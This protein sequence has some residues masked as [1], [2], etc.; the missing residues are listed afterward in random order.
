MQR[1]WQ[2]AAAAFSRLAARDACGASGC[3]AAAAL[4]GASCA[5]RRA[6]GGA[7]DTSGDGGAPGGAASAPVAAG[8]AQAEHAALLH[9]ELSRHGRVEAE[10]VQQARACATCGLNAP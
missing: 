1:L 2:P 6:F 3:H 4:G 5:A 7:V 8:A 9:A 10:L